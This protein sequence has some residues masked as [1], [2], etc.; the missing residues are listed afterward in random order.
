MIHDNFVLSFNGKN[1]LKNDKEMNWERNIFQV[2]TSTDG[3]GSI[4]ASPMSG[5][6]GTTVSLSNTPNANY[7]FQNYTLTGATL[8][9]NQFMLNNDVT[10]MANFSALPT[11]RKLGDTVNA[12][13]VNSYYDTTCEPR[14]LGRYTYT[15]M[16]YTDN[17]NTAYVTYRDVVNS[18]SMTLY[19]APYSGSASF[20]REY[21]NI[22]GWSVSNDKSAGNVL[23]VN[24]GQTALVDYVYATFSTVFSVQS[25]Y[26]AYRRWVLND[27]IMPTE[28][29]PT[30]GLWR[31]SEPIVLTGTAPTISI[32]NIS[33]TTAS[34][35][36]TATATL[37]YI[38]WSGRLLE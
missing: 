33:T 13:Y 32:K 22:N 19:P 34:D 12:F 29:S 16:Y 9:G 18:P 27:N 26:T 31:L 37:S 3:H 15:P 21:K 14:I 20:L 23:K 36:W 30:Y 2:T 17:L 28:G 6:Q 35:S 8:T 1:L 25:P 5:Y 4:T 38:E 10:A 11:S 24:A 7:G